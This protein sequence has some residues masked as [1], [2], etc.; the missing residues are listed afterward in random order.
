MPSG[1]WAQGWV[2]TSY[3]DVLW[4]HKLDWD[5]HILL[6]LFRFRLRNHSS[7]IIEDHLYDI[8]AWARWRSDQPISSLQ[9]VTNTAQIMVG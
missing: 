1:F 7:F 8:L 4:P 6:C 9:I 5:P 3:H 2:A